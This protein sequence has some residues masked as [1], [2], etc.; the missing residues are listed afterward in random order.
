MP[1]RHTGAQ[2]RWRRWRRGRHG[3]H[4]ARACGERLEWLEQENQ[5]LQGLAQENARAHDEIERLQR[6]VERMKREARDK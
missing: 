2:R 1:T 3:P 6:E 4:R 5:H